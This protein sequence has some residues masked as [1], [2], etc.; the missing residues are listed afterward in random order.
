MLV[1]RLFRVGKKNQ[2]AFKIVVTDKKNPP[3]GGRF[4]E[5]VGFYNP[6]TKKKI[7]KTERIKY[8]ISVGAQPSATVFNLLVS[9]KVLEG[10]KIPSHKKSKKKEEK[11]VEPVAVKDAVVEPGGEK[12]AEGAPIEEEKSAKEAAEK[13]EKEVLK[14]E[15]PTETKASVPEKLVEEPQKE[16]KQVPEKPTEKETEEKAEEPAKEEVKDVPEKKEPTKEPNPE[17]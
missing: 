14:K 17:E 7:L 13:P 11:P 2:P 5:Q 4:V 12:P 8:W 1:I 16:E 3:R 9:E 6:L 10:D 15:E